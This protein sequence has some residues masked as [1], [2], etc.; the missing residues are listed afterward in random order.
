MR[1]LKFF[2]WLIVPVG[3]A[4]FLAFVGYPHF[5]WSYT[6][7][8]GGSYDVASRYYTSCTFWGPSGLVT[9]QNPANG[10]CGWVIFHKT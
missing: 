7:R 6:W 9:I 3:I 2:G 8:S 4:A 1:L 5:I 10:R